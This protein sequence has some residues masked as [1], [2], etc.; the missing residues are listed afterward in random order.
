MAVSK[1]LRYEVMRR[2]GHTCR[3]CGATTADAKLTIDHVKPVALGGTDEP[4][5]LVTACADCNGGKSS[6]SPDAA[7]VADVADDALRWKQAQDYAM[8]MWRCEHSRIEAAINEFESHWG[9]WKTGTMPVPM[10]PDWRGSVDAWLKRGFTEWDL[11]D[12]IPTAMRKQDVSPHDKWRYFCGIVWRT[13]DQ[14]EAEAHRRIV[15]EVE[16]DE[17]APSDVYA[18]GYIEGYQA[19][20]DAMN[21][22]I[23]TLHQAMHK[24]RR[25]LALRIKKEIGYTPLV[26]ILDSGIDEIRE[27]TEARG[28]F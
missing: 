10:D 27:L 19:G 22:E 3:Y 17:D 23:E 11:I 7:L 25:R 24:L 5:N 8:E 6:S 26:E 28:P 12:M 2:D 13:L 16:D 1:R 21:S 9:D 14:I 4:E 18:E 15:S 20:M